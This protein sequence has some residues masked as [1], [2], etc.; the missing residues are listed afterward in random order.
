MKVCII[1]GGGGGSNAA[2]TIRGLDKTAQ[3]D[4]FTDRGEIGNLPCEIPFVLQGAL[5]SW[6]ASFAFRERFYWE[7]NIKVHFNSEVTQLIRE[8]KQLVTR[9]ETHAYDKAILDVGAVPSIPPIPGRDGQNEFVMGTDLK[10][11]RALEKVIPRYTSAAIFGVGQIGLEMAAALRVRGYTHVY[12]IGRSDRI[13]RSYLDRDMADMVEERLKENGIEL[14]LQADI[15]GISTGRGG[16]LVSLSD[17]ALEV[18]FVL[19][20]TGAEPNSILAQRS[21]IRLGESGAI[22]VNEYL[23][24]SD[25]DIYAIGD[26][27]ENWDI[28]TGTRSC[29]Q[30]ATNAAKTGRIAGRNLVLGNVVRYR[31][32]VMPF[33]IDIFG[34]E[35]GTVGFT[36]AYAWELGLETVSSV[37]ATSTRRRAFGGKP[38]HIK[39]IADKNARTL[40]GAQVISEELV[41]AKID[42]LAV[43][44]AE[45]IPVERLSQ[46]DTGYSP[47]VG[48][49]YEALTM[50][51]DALEGSLEANR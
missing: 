45:R 48:A 2:N 19:F 36:E 21:G 10:Y 28:L 44:I 5:P 50:A 27:M 51:L 26:C 31:G 29:Y 4:I 13:L 34:C 33:V 15:S 40:V 42:R 49:G 23:Q 17:R 11:G 7:R 38:I 8:K 35:V 43:A 12:L 14:I 6:E 41:A 22:A 47:T 1:G 39:L 18:G 30:T 16:K 46:I 3:I 32:T 25:P 9:G 37:T 20:A 24:T